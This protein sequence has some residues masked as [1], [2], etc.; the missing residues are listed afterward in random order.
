MA[1]QAKVTS[2]DA[3]QSFRSHTILFLTK[4]RRALDQAGDE[5][6]RARN[7]VQTDQRS[8]W[9]GQ[10]R[11]RQRAL[12]QA[13]AELMSARMS[14]FVDSP[15]LQQSN[16]RKA[17]AAVQEA[18]QKLERVKAWNRNFD[19]AFDPHVRKLEVLRE[20]IDHDM[21]KALA[22]LD[23]VQKILE[24]YTQIGGPAPGPSPAAPPPASGAEPEQ[25]T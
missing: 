3:L 4:A 11:R 23:Q 16:V 10:I 1:E 15:T 21:P 5:V 2:L 7:W 17:K 9:E 6:R 19:T 14:E 20:F 13:E 12:E 25:G 22:Y 8:H 18:E 24:S